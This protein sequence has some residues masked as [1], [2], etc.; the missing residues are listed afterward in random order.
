MASYNKVVVVGNLTRDVELKTLSNGTSVGEFGL[1][2]N[3]SYVDKSTGSKVDTPVFLDVTVWA[4]QAETAAKYIGKGSQVLVDGKL[5]LDIWETENG[6]KRQK[7]RVVANQIQFL[8]KQL[9]AD[10]Q[11]WDHLDDEPDNL[12]QDLDTEDIPF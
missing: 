1:A 11:S 10:D 7:L 6:D 3:D 12:N 2:I 9:D 4:R 5:K 8:S